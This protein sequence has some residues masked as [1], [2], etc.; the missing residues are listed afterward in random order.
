MVNQQRWAGTLS[1]MQQHSIVRCCS[2]PT[3]GW[4]QGLGQSSS[5]KVEKCSSHSS[6]GPLW[7][8][9]EGE[10]KGGEGRG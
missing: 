7:E 2:S 4:L 8:G 6:S 1:E 5:K 9:R 10:G 3:S